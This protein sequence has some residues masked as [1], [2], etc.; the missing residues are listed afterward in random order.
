M[1][2]IALVTPYHT[3]SHARWADGL[4]CHSHHEVSVFS[5]PGRFWK[6]RMHGGAIS[7][8]RDVLA[9][10]VTYDLIL[11]TDMLDLTTFQAITRRRYANTP[12]AVYF[13]ENQLTYPPPPG[14]KRDLHYGFINYASMVAADH[15]FFNST[16]HRDAL[17]DEL[18][19]LLKHF[20]DYNELDT[21]D[22]I[23]RKSTVLPLGLDLKQL[24][25]HQPLV[26]RSGPLRI[27]WNHRWEYDK[28]PVQFFEA[29]YAL[30]SA[31]MPFEVIILGESFRQRPG[32]FL[33]AQ[34]LL[35]EHIIH[36][37]YT[38]S[39]AEYAHLLWAGD[40]QVS[41]AIQ[42]FFGGATCEAIYCN[43]YPLL[44]D[45]LNY[46]TFIPSDRHLQHLYRDQP[47]LV[48]LLRDACLNVAE[49]RKTSLRET[50]IQY[51]WDAIIETYDSAFERLMAQ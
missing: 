12:M 19:R 45:R 20:P 24:D 26:R 42:D 30:Q 43:C 50:V 21:L 47:G 7:L 51:D 33:E 18:P 46:P 4:A 38:E 9:Q 40:V 3:G 35:A 5:L 39:F 36:T 6:W 49:I 17:L 16:Y 15:V 27:L 34:K 2:R 22:T 25:A 41:C 37:G 28:Q 10:D 1:G 8:A 31:G 48:K 32:E 14:Q 11:T 44:P 23:A 13:H 29:L